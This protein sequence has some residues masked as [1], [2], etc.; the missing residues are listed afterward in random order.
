VHFLVVPLQGDRDLSAITKHEHIEVTDLP[1]IRTYMRQL[2][3]AVQYLHDVAGVVHGDIKR[4]LSVLPSHFLC[5][6]SAE[7]YI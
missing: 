4:K 6:C 1:T 7:H 5:C 2:L 3:R